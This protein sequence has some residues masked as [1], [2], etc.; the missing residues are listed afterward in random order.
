[1]ARLKPALL[2]ILLVLVASAAIARQRGESS[3]DPMQ[4]LLAEVHELRLAIERQASVGAR[5]QLLSSRVALQDERVFKLLQQLE[6]V[7]REIMGVDTQLKQATERDTRFDEAINA[8]VDPKQRQEFEA[9][10]RLMKAERALQVNMLEALRTREAELASAA[11]TEQAKLDEV[12]RRLDELERAL[13]Q[14]Q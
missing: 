9:Q 5:V 8:E 13:S 2:P 6:N 3:P 7:R 11:A 12:T 4:R 1:M 10:R 14:P